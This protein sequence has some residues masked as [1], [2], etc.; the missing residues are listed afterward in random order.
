MK[1]A[2]LATIPRR[3]KSLAQVLTRLRPQVDRLYV[4]C[5]GYQDLPPSVRELADDHATSQLHGDRGDAGKMFWLDRV[6]ADA[7]YLSCDDDIRY[8]ENYVAVLVAACQ[9]YRSRIAVGVH[10]GRVLTPITSYYRCRKMRHT[11]AGFEQDAWVNLLGTGTLCFRPGAVGIQPKDFPN[12]FM[13]DVWF[14]VHCQ[15][16]GIPML[17][18]ARPKGW[19]GDLPCGSRVDSLHARHHRD[20]RVQTQIMQTINRWQVHR[21]PNAPEI[22]AA[23]GG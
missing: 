1:V 4:Y 7:Y 13:A 9:A 19:L 18:I 17:S 23:R 20:D 5:N 6:P 3:E 22:P 12:G 16:A 21:P 10:G 8:P 15:R 2:C 11:F 14:A